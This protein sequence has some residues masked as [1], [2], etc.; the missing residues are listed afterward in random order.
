MGANPG[1]VA[2]PVRLVPEAKTTGT[3]KLVTKLSV[4]YLTKK[5]SSGEGI[6]VITTSTFTG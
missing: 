2:V 1:I 3:I 5:N 4:V 6:D